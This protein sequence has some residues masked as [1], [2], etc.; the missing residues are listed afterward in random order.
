MNVYEDAEDGDTSRWNPPDRNSQIKVVH[1][2]ERD[3]NVI[4]FQT[5]GR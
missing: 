5:A 2:E 3:S 1:D 4:E